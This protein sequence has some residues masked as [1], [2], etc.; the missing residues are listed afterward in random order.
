MKGWISWVCEIHRRSFSGKIFRFEI[1]FRAGGEAE[2]R[3]RSAASVTVEII[4]KADARRRFPK[5]R[6]SAADARQ[7]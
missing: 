3:K 2:A 7:C 1:K 6:F 5:I 4:A